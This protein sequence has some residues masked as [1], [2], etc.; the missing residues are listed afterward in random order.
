M[1]YFHNEKELERYRKVGERYSKWME[2]HWYKGAKEKFEWTD[3]NLRRILALNDAII[4]K[5]NNLYR[6]LSNVKA[7]IE[8]LL[9]S[10]KDYYKYYDIDAYLSYEAEDYATPTGDED[11]MSDVYFVT[12]FE[13]CMGLYTSADKPLLSVEEEFDRDINFNYDGVF[14]DIPDKNHFIT[15]SL[16]RLMEEETYTLEDLLWLNPDNFVECIEIRN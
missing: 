7:D 5:E 6:L 1:R 13:F 11:T 3:E 15:R 16:H 10:G 14:K 8:N 12:N 2:D 4:E 9:A